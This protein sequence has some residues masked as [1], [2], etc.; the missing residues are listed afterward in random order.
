MTVLHPDHDPAN[1][2]G[3]TRF[4]LEI[5]DRLATVGI[6]NHLDDNLSMV[7]DHEM[8]IVDIDQ[9]ASQYQLP[10][11]FTVP[12][13]TRNTSRTTKADTETLTYSIS[14]W[15][16]DYNQPYAMVQAQIIVGNIVNN[17]ENRRSLTDAN[18]NDPLAE[19]VSKTETTYDFVLNPREERGHLKYGTAKFEVKTKRK[20]PTGNLVK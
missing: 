13:G 9:L 3:F 4:Q 2:E 18:G 17:I 15:V 6:E 12:T 5:Y 8:G 16:S 14:A 10:V 20:I 19:D 1:Y 7:N 11:V